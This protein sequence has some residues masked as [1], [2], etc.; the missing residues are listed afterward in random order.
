MIINVFRDRPLVIPGTRLCEATFGIV[1]AR[2]PD[3]H[4]VQR[5][6]EVQSVFAPLEGRALNGVRTKLIDQKGFVGFCNQRDLEVL[7]GMAL[8]G[9]YCPWAEEE[10]VGPEDEGWFGLCCDDEDLLDD[11]Y[12][13]EMLLR[14]QV[15]GGVITTDYD[16]ERRV[17]LDKNDDHEELFVLLGD[18][19]METGMFPD[20]RFE[21]LERRW[22]RSERRRVR[23]NRI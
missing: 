12:E 13:R 4:N 20:Q 23:W 11:L 17:H 22:I 19:D 8:P 1:G 9:T 21:T 7:L 16:I 2:I 18:Y 3:P 15:P 14:A 6:W 10:Y 5:I